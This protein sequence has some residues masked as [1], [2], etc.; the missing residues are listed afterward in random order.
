MKEEH[1]EELRE[2]LNQET[3]L[4]E[5]DLT[6][7]I[8]I[9]VPMP[10]DYV[11]ENLINELQI[12]EPFGKGNEKPIFAAKNLEILGARIIGQNRN[13][14]KMRVQSEYGKVMDA[15]YFGDQEESDSSV[16]CLL[17]GDQ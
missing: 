13:V 15:I 17:P 9:D 3:T 5:E 2:K 8:R 16:G 10:V 4:T 7:K 11:S 6:E 14:C 12:L 1:I